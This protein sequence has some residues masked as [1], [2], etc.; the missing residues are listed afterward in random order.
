MR[1]LRHRITTLSRRYHKLLDLAVPKRNTTLATLA[2]LVKGPFLSSEAGLG[3]DSVSLEHWQKRTAT[4]SFR[5]TQTWMR[6]RTPRHR[7]RR[8]EYVQLQSRLKLRKGRKWRKVTPIYLGFVFFFLWGG[9]RQGPCVELKQ[10]T[11]GGVKGA[12]E[13]RR[14]INSWKKKN[15]YK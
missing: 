15:S 2:V 3:L 6:G 5:R 11:W 1:K 14:A 10:S 13:K 12:A 9:R 8:W 4:D 7:K